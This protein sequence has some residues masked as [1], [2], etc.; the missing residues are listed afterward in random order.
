MRYEK[1]SDLPDTI[2]DVLPEA[3]QQIYLEAYQRSYDDYEEGKGGQLSRG[4]VAHRDG[5]MALQHEYE[6]DKETG[7]WHR[8]DEESREAGGEEEGMRNVLKKVR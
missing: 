6:Q 4:S 5:W 8:K 2:R 3:A 7:E 1:K